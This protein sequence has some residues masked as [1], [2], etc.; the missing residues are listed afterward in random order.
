MS[1]AG[2]YTSRYF[3]GMKVEVGIPLLNT[4]VFRDWAIV[5]EID[6]DLVSLQLSRDMLPEGVNLRVGQILTIRSESEGHVYFCR[7]FIVSKGY[8]QDLLLRLTGEI[9]S[10]ELRE[11]YRIDAYLPIKFYGLHDQDPANVKKRWEER[12]K[13]RHNEERMRERKRLEARRERIRS[14][15]R[16]REQYLLD[17]EAS[18]EPFE[19]VPRGELHEE[20]EDNPY[21]VSWGSVTAVAVNI[22]GGGLMI[23]TDQGFEVDE[24]LLL[25]IFVPSASRIVDIVARVVFSHTAVSNGQT[26][27]HTGM[28]FVYIDERARFAVNSH[29][30]GIQIQRIRNFKGFSDAEP[31]YSGSVPLPDRQYAYVDQV[32][33]DGPA[34]D[35]ERAKRKKIIQQTVL[36]LFLLGIVSLLCF[37]FAGYATDRPRSEIQDLFENGL[38]N[39]GGNWMR[40]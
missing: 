15:E 34:D 11:F 2:L 16:A 39:F 18:G 35:P 6:E 27:F 17:R 20:P 7:A 5:N 1:D 31:L 32:D 13:Q 28:Q 14:E 21:Y 26:C 40:K 23:M 9:V 24:F 36:G 37:Y 33:G 4:Q 10:D 22:G 12:R 3:I 30:S 25:E 29:I 8:D 38:R 19:P